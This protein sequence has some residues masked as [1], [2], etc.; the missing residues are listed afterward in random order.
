M[1]TD[2]LADLL[3]RLKNAQL[4]RKP[5]VSAPYSRAK[6][7][8]LK[9]LLKNNLIQAYK[10]TGKKPHLTLDISLKYHHRQPAMA[11]LKRISKPGV[12][13]YAPVADLSRYLR[14]RGLTIL[15][16]SKGLLTALQAKKQNLGGE[17][18]C[19]IK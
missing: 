11:E 4:V 8:I 12:R 6:E 5:T 2:P 10:V 18:V 16:T 19:K 1:L 17:V 15:S 9:I 7:S 13:I 3:S 14:G